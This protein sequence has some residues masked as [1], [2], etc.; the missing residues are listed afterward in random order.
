MACRLM[1]LHSKPLRI[2]LRGGQVLV[3][4]PGERS[5]A[6]REELLYDN[7]HVPDWERLGWVRRIAARLSDVTAEAGVAPAQAPVA[8]GSASAA[9]PAV[10]SKVVPGVRGAGASAAVKK[11]PAK[12]QR[13]APS[14]PRRPK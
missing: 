10:A 12:P 9:A 8:V 6:L 3:L 5:A 14:K 11:V 4:A 2:D 1:N 7:H 13:A